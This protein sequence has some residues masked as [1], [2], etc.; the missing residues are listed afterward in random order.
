MIYHDQMRFI[1]GILECFNMFTNYPMWYIHHINKLKNKII[2]SSQWLGKK[3]LKNST[4][5]YDK[6]SQQVGRVETCFDILKLIVIKPTAN[7]M[8]KSKKQK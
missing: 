3:I 1:P 8:L 6:N 5:I 4:S 7:I 2:W